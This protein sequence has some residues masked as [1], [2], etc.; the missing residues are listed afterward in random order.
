MPEYSVPVPRYWRS[1]PVYYRLVAARCRYCGK[2]YY[3]PR[4]RCVCG[5]RDLELVSL[6][7]Q[8]GEF[9]LVDYTVLHSVS[10][11]FEKQKPLIFGLVRCEKLSLIIISAL[12]DIVNVEDLAPGIEVEPVFRVIKRD[13]SYGIVCYGTKFRIAAREVRT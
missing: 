4:I 6:I 7:E 8:C 3:P 13:G 2:T 9:K 12:T 11:D 1:I 10:V 5:S